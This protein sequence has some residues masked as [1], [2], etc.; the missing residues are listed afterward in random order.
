M[1]ALC[2]LGRREDPPSVLKALTLLIMKRRLHPTFRKDFY[3]AN[4][5][6]IGFA[7]ASLLSHFIL[8]FEPAHYFAFMF[9]AIVLISIFYHLR[10]ERKFRDATCANC[11]HRGSLIIPTSRG[12]HYVLEC[13]ICQIEWNLNVKMVPEN[14]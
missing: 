5:F 11:G 3:K 12:G 14:D 4:V 9:I 7:L 2:A 13:D 1:Y 6:I 8:G 10:K